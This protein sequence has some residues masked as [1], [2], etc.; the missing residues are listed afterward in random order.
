MEKL[1]DAINEATF[2][3]NPEKKGSNEKM[4]TQISQKL[5]KDTETIDLNYKVKC[6]GNIEGWLCTLEKNM[7]LTIQ[8]IARRA[9]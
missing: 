3:K 7:Q 4:I 1:F 8:D 5:G 2:E 9:C 6:E